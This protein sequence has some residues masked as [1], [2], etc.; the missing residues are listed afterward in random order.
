MPDGIDTLVGS[1]GNSMSGGQRQRVAI[2]RARL[3]DTPILI[4]DE[5]TSALD[6][7]T[8]SLVMDAI[9]EWR[10]GKT[11]IIITHD[12]SQILK[13]D[14]VYLLSKGVIMQEGYR[15]ALE[16]GDGGLFK[17]FLPRKLDPSVAQPGPDEPLPTSHII[18]IHSP[19]S[20][21]RSSVISHDSMDFSFE[22]RS[23]F[24][25]SVFGAADEDTQRPSLATQRR[26]SFGLISPLS[27]MVYPG[28]L[29]SQGRSSILSVSRRTTPVTRLEPALLSSSKD[30]EMV[31]LTGRHAAPKR[32][33]EARQVH[34]VP[35][36]SFP[37]P[38]GIP[39][40]ARIKAV[41][42]KRK[43]DLTKSE[44][45]RRI[46]P[47]HKILATV[48]PTLPWPKRICLVLGFVCA[49]IHAAATPIFS[50]VFSKLLAT[51]FVANGRSQALTW[52]LSVLGVA[53]GDGLASYLMHY[54][55]EVCGQAWVDALRIE[56]FKRILD[57]P[58]SWFDRD[59]N[60]ISRLT[61]CL[62]RNAEEMRNLLGRFAAFVFV[63]VTM[64]LMAVIWSLILNWKLTLVGLASAPL[65][66]GLSRGF[67]AVSGKWEGRSN[68][69]GD[70]A[71]SIFTETFISIR[72][73]R[74]LTLEG[75][76]HRKYAKATDKAIKVGLKRSAYSGLFFGLSDSAII[77]ITGKAYM[78]AKQALLLLTQSSSYLLLRCHL[79]Y[80]AVDNSRHP[81]GLHYA[82]VQ[83][84]QC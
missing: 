74:A 19:E 60:S 53:V 23:R 68:D 77:F 11:T 61:E 73:I 41:L 8:R 82:T 30:M 42:P 17:S 50:W 7:M 20:S 2:A 6:P 40:Q 80:R 21:P 27:P 78:L 25:P 22:P 84:R 67:E 39:R 49:F 37:L 62:D 48:W 76:F 63:A 33:K 34:R 15:N 46:L 56:A 79:R 29:I 66:Y 26:S 24:I 70:A 83:Y 57:Q 5:A 13:D 10:T 64:M 81:N 43:R 31:E 71:S 1:G 28:G 55:L 65:L 75:Y 3:R 54:L 44:K 16:S 36:S 59:K 14:Y 18:S 38:V 4:L 72:T 51:F 35:E 47:I 58:R 9:R 69:A 52:S 32:S 45:D 12:I